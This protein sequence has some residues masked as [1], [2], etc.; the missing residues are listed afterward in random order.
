VISMCLAKTAPSG[1]PWHL[2]YWLQRK[3]IPHF[4]GHVTAGGCDRSRI[5]PRKTV[6]APGGWDTSREACKT[7]GTALFAKENLG[8]AF[9]ITATGT[10]NEAN[11]VSHSLEGFLAFGR[12][13]VSPVYGWAGGP[14][15]ELVS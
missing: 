13:G 8:A 1:W 14:L 2:D 12:R 3:L 15:E 4:D 9:V 7:S 5:Y 10:L 6:S 11:G